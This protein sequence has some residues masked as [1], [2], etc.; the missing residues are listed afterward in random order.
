MTKRAKNRHL[1]RLFE[2]IQPFINYSM[3]LEENIAAGKVMVIAPHED[4]EAIGCAGTIIKYAREGGHV[5]TVF[6]THENASRRK[7]AENSAAIMGSKKN[8]FLQYPLRS[9]SN[10]SGFQDSLAVLFNQ[11]EPDI[12][13][14]PF[15]FD[16]HK[17]HQAVSKALIK[18]SKKISLDFMVYAY[19][20]W[21]PI[22]PNVLI[23]I[24]DEWKAKKA[25]IEC[26]KTQLTGRD[27]VRIAK[28]SAEYWAEVK[29]PKSGYFEAFFRASAKEYIRLG[30]KIF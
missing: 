25:A 29:K 20:V 15:W 10:E 9:L 21:L 24:S 4:D 2:Y 28:A 23:D 8:H 19:P 13:F 12:V 11:I 5:E 6:C 1:F 27:Y 17:D 16:N 26:Y 3:P 30:K 14:M 22:Y 7:E 18:I